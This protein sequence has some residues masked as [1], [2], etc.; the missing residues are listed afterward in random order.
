MADY[1]KKEIRRGSHQNINKIKV[2]Y[3]IYKIFTVSSNQSEYLQW[4]NQ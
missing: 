2:D 1:N 4:W 3:P